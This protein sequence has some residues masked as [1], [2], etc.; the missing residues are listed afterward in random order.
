MTRKIRNAISIS[1][2]TLLGLSVSNTALAT[3]E[4][5]QVNIRWE[6]WNNANPGKGGSV[7]AV[8]DE[9]DVVANAA[10]TPDIKDFHRLHN[11]F[12]L[13]D[14]NFTGNEIEMKYTSIAVRDFDHQYMYMSSRGFH[15]EDT[16]N[17]LPDIV[18]VTVDNRFAPFGFDPNL[19][20]FDAN[21][22]YVGLKG[23]MCHTEAMNSMPTCTNPASPTGYDNQIKLNVQFAASAAPTATSVN[24]AQIDAF[25]N[26]A[27]KKYPQYFPTTQASATLE[28]YYARHYAATNVY[29]GV[30]DGKLFVL[31]EPFGGL[32]PL[33]DVAKWLKEAGI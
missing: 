22:I 1:M 4:G 21:N 30:K 8:R 6:I 24:K 3:F 7:L 18:N 33:G 16:E 5:K 31:G 29:M 27:E 13:W 19:V 26:W 32:L 25:F 11:D 9:R 17:N 10:N 14:V 20:S 2:M 28:G 23:S 15:F 12:E